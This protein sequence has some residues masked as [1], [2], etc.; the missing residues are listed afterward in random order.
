MKEFKPFAALLGLHAPF[1][2][3]DVQLDAAGQRIELIV[4]GDKRRGWFKK[5]PVQSS[6]VHRWQHLSLCG[7]RCFVQLAAAND[8]ALLSYPWSGAPERP[9]TFALER[10]VAAYLREGI[11]LQQL[12]TL[13]DV[14]LADVW[15]FKFA[16]DS[17]K[18]RWDGNTVMAT[19]PT[20]TVFAPTMAPALGPV[21]TDRAGT[22]PAA[23]TTSNTQV[24]HAEHPLWQKLAGGE[25]DINIRAFSLK[26][27]L[28]RIRGQLKLIDDTQ[29]RAMKVQ[30]VHRFFVHNEAVLA[31]EL[32]QLLALR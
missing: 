23:A 2:L 25:L 18:V 31:F 11:S 8:R 28:T 17:G 13:L 19:P 22:R 1:K 5:S 9:F 29:I 20:S 3:V 27:L 32:H 16:L 21:S 14:S 12:C 15:K 10:L 7:S 24:P 30:Q 6:V 26:L 4:N